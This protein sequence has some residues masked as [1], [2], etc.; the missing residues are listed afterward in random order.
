MIKQAVQS[1]FAILATALPGVATSAVDVFIVPRLELQ[2]G[3]ENN[4]LEESGSG[5]GS[6]FWQATP[7][8]DVTMFG[9]K[10]EASL[11]LDYRRTQYTKSGFESK[12]EAS[13]FAQWRYFG[14]H[15]EAGVGVGGGWYRDAVLSDSDSLFWQARPYFVHTMKG[16]P[17]EMSLKGTFRQ[18]LYEVSVYTSATDRVDSRMEVRPGFRWHPSRKATVWAEFYAERNLSD[19]REAEYS[20]FGG[21]FGCE[22]R[23]SARLALGAWVEAGSRPYEEQVENQDRTDSPRRMGAWASYR[24]RPWLELFSL[25]DWESF[26]ST[27]DWNEY[28][29]WRASMGVKLVF[30][31]E[32]NIH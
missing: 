4:R 7:G 18:T 9:E 26:S 28:S 17:A 22:F 8:L 16:I 13:A 24:L 31:H 20:G 21:A 3:Y 14:G 12:D 30:E 10:T 11:W 15:N 19:A 6:P 27:I 2:A 32:M 29:W 25:A 1:A 23:P 5:E